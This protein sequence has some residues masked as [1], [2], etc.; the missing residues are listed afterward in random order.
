MT[1]ISRIPP[2]A[3]ARH[4]RLLP[5]S[6]LAVLAALCSFALLAAPAGAV[7]SEVEGT[8]V[9]LQPR[10]TNLVFPSGSFSNE[11]GSPIVN[12]ASVYAVYWDPG[13]W[14]HHEW[15]SN[16]DT[17][18][19]QL[20][21]GSGE[22][23]TIFS[24]LGQYRDRTNAQ[25][26]YNFTFKGAYSD[27]TP[28]P[29]AGCTDPE[30]L[31]FGQITCL[32]DAQVREEL[33]SF[34]ASH[35]T[36]KGMHSVY[37][38]LT[39]PG[40][41]VC[42][43]GGST[44]CSDYAL[45]EEEIEEGERNSTSYKNSF[46]SYHGAINPGKAATGDANTILYAAI[47]WT[48]G[49]E[50][51]P[52]DFVPGPSNGGQAYDCQDGGWNPEGAEENLEGQPHIQEPN[53]EGKG[54]EGDYA[55]ALTDVLVNQIAEEQ[56]NIVTNPLL[57][58]WQN[59]VSRREATDECRN[60]F[61]ATASPSSIK[62]EAVKKAGTEAGN[63]E[64]E[65]I[66]GGA[67]YV[68]NVFNA[69]A[70]H[71][72]GSCVGGVGLVP[73]FTSPNPV[74]SGEL[75]AFDGMGSTVSEF[76]GATFGPSGPPTTTYATFEWNF[77][78]GTGEVKG[79]APG[80][81]ACSVPWLSPCAASTFHS[82]VYGGKHTVTL[83]ITDVAGNVSNVSNDVVVVGP[84]PPT[85]P[86]V[87]PPG[88]GATGASTT[89]AGTGT[90]S[91]GSGSKAPGPIVTTPV[92]KAGVASRSLRTAL[93]RG[94]AV[95]Y[96]VNEQVAGRFEVL[97]ARSVASK[98]KIGGPAATG[99]PAGTPPQVVIAKAVLVTTKG[100]RS[101]VHIKFS[102]KIAARL[103]HVHA[104]PL[105]LRLVVRNASASSPE[106]ATVLSSVTLSG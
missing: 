75:V 68:N 72:G 60:V 18:L 57:T 97:M 41:S 77:G 32:N 26:R 34:I 29:T 45:S 12:G 87:S 25:A 33:Q 46:C 99:L 36:P 71:G 73:R 8:Q 24:A 54:E 10:T 9:G 67:Y 52:W 53:Q 102:K 37:Y 86:A 64:N 47:P 5:L 101:T 44:H 93:R 103:K 66:A 81:P 95:T 106:T 94:L 15:V 65:L 82:Y 3:G 31:E 20:G 85:P 56:A 58:S 49:Y 28:Y 38:L 59:P 76:K 27:T 30:A 69:G 91:S 14:F 16:I 43:T 83:T 40:V 89:G 7:V 50:G 98:L 13:A 39:P 74:N 78:D 19:Q 35:G 90:G 6:V 51:Q 48:A 105:M 21:A 11:S 84:P 100:G 17:F 1:H 4:R 23:G 61:A 96:S 62:G 79:F 42:L 92:A 2:R 80:A 22:F 104:A 63:L 88:S 55:P 70:L